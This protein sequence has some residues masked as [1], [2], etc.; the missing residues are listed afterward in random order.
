MNEDADLL[1]EFVR[2]RDQGSFRR[3]VE[4]RIGFVHAVALRRLRDPHLA[5][6]ATQAV[7][8]AL[9]RK[10]G[11][12]AEGPSVIGWL[13]RSTCYEAGNMIRSRMHRQSRES[14]AQRLGLAGGE[15]NA[16]ALPAGVEPVLD[17]LLNELPEADREAL[18][19]RFFA[20]RSYA[21]IG[22]ATE[23]SDN[24][25]RMRVDRALDKL[26][27]RLRRR[28]F[29]SSAAVLAAALTAYAA[30]A[31]P[32]GLAGTVATAALSALGTAAA[33]AALLG[34]MSMGKIMATGAAVA[35]AGFIG[36]QH[37]QNSQLA[38]RLRAEQAANQRH[39]TWMR[40]VEKEIAELKAARAAAVAEANAATARAAEA[41]TPVAAPAAMS[42]AERP[43]ITRTPP[44]G[45][46]KNGTK[47]EVFDVGVDHTEL[48]GGMPSAYAR[49]DIADAA[50][51]FGGMMQ[52]IAAEK[53]KNQRIRLSGWIK[54]S[55]VR[56]GGAHLWL[57]VDGENPGSGRMLAFDNMQ[58]RAPTGNSDWQEY[59]VVVDV[60]AAASS[61]NYGFFLRG[62]GQMWVNALQV[63][64]VGTDMP[65]TDM[66]RSEPSNLGFAAGKPSG[67]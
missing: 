37:H 12:V 8:I 6:D 28:G 1:R 59:S 64:T 7:F 50:K 27:E 45:W 23:R 24:A 61:L 62:R 17:E 46:R 49:A 9:A 52:T 5:Q 18:L 51:E 43:G 15:A 21:E 36:F 30:G 63:E 31:A 55:D 34:F 3:L 57:R 25:V 16:G 42:A 65:S 35:A 32:A 29:E 56:D 48:W 4:R 26:R 40:E 33:P 13:H 58:N 14:E 2:G 66:I 60:P 44:A 47:P 11:R 39:A 20:G 22:A 67:G 54:T 38:E 10:A 19:A 41:R 53:Y